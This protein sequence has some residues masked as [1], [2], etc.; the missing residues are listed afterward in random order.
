MIL[1]KII[2]KTFS[3]KFLSFYIYIFFLCQIF[4]R[5]SPPCCFSPTPTENVLF[6][7]GVSTSDKLFHETYC[8]QTEKK[9]TKEFRTQKKSHFPKKK[10]V[11][12]R[13]EKANSHFWCARKCLCEPTKLREFLAAKFDASVLAT[14]SKTQ[15]DIIGRSPP[16]ICL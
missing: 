10:C 16:Q 12:V 2:A 6:M 1:T 8:L 7:N 3:S 14:V 4:S 9:K 13:K 5:I 11:W 15:C